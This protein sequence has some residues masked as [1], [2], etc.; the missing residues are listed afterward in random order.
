MKES[1]KSQTNKKWTSNDSYRDNYKAIF[2][3]KSKDK[4]STDVKG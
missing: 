4:A 2:K 1:Q 3:K